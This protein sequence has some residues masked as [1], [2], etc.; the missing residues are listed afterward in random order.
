MNTQRFFAA[1]ALSSLA[2]LSACK[3]DGALMQPIDSLMGK[4]QAT[5]ERLSTEAAAAIAEGRTQEALV[6]Y[7]ALYETHKGDA[8]IA[9]NYAQLLRKTGDIDNAEK[10]LAPFVAGRNSDVRRGGEDGLVMNEYA[11]VLIA[12][13]NF[14]DAEKTLNAVLEDAKETR[15]HSDARNL[16]GVSLDARGQHREAEQ[17]FRLA[18]DGWKGNPSSV[19]NNLGLCLAAGGMFDESLDTLRR[20][21]ILSPDKSEIA[22]N[23]QIVTGLRDQVIKRPA[24]PEAQAKTKPV[25]KIA[26]AKK[27]L[28]KIS[29]KPE[30]KAEEKKAEAPAISPSVPPA[31]EAAPAAVPAAPAPGSTTP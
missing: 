16:M 1:I 15:H 3:T 9:V 7:A 2:L 11:A 10:V 13:G 17:M 4:R 18:L 27:K 29:P 28:K 12:Q 8:R 25:K 31:P 23:I 6:R 20:A 21:L 24:V 22:S 19:L 26:P 30:V 5:E 14:A